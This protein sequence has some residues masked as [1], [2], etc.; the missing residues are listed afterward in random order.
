VFSTIAQPWSRA[1]VA[2]AWLT[3]GEGPL[4]ASEY[5]FPAGAPLAEVLRI[6][7][8]GRPVQRR[9]TLPRLSRVP[10]LAAAVSVSYF[11]W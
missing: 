6:L 7:R 8:E 11:A 9:L 5:G 3:R 4:R 10:L 2:A 1:F